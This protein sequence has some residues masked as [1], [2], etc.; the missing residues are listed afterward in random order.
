MEPLLAL[1]PAAS[2]MT[3]APGLGHETTGMLTA[4]V[5]ADGAAVT[6]CAAGEVDMRSAPLLADALHAACEA[7]APRTPLVVDL[8]GIRFFAGAGLTLL[9]TTRRRCQERQVPLV[10]VAPASV[11]RPLRLTGLDGL[12][13]L[14]AP[15][16]CPDGA[17]GALRPERWS[18]SAG[19]SR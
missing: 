4:T 9:L 14:A 12:F 16:G 11:L 10:V 17:A 13:T 6:V 5:D 7:A 2:P 15:A 19:S 8:S 18:R 1:V 3:G